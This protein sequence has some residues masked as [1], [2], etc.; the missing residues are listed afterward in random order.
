MSASP[1]P[2]WGASLADASASDWITVA[3]YLLAAL[4]AMRAARVAARAAARR[5]RVFWSL[6]AGLL[7]FLAFNELFDLQQLL[8]AVGKARALEQGWYAER[9]LYQFEFILGL[10]VAAVLGG[11]AVLWLTRAAHRSLRWALLGLVFIGAFVLVRAASFHHVDALL[12]MGPAEF[13]WGSLQELAGIAIVGLAA[14][15]YRPALRTTA[16]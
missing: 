14:A 6:V 13:N 5:D 12:G 9:R 10:A 15:R 3:A 4:V 1:W 8:T 11:L 2:D 16:A 7:V